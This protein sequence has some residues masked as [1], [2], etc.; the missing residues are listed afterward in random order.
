MNYKELVNALDMIWEEK[1]R[2]DIRACRDQAYHLLDSVHNDFIDYAFVN[3]N[4]QISDLITEIND[5]DIDIIEDALEEAASDAIF[6]GLDLYLGYILAAKGRLTA[7]GHSPAKS[8]KIFKAI[9]TKELQLEILERYDLVPLILQDYTADRLDFLV[10]EIP[11]LGKCA[12]SKVEGL[13]QTLLAL[14]TTSFLITV[15]HME[16]M[17]SFKA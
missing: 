17:Y 14:S 15:I 11:S 10:E 1:P 2:L 9:E 16:D 3:L 7:T 5:D 12:W 6:L 13:R 8:E 4:E